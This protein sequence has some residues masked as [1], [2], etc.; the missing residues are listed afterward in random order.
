MAKGS[1]KQVGEFKIADMVKTR[2]VVGKIVS[3][4][5]RR[6]AIVE[7][8]N[9]ERVAVSILDLKRDEANQEKQVSGGN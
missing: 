5:T 4:P 1:R 9:G 3:F 6:V 8:R 7:K 2:T